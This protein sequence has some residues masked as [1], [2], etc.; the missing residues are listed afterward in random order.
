M[1]SNSRPPVTCA[2]CGGSTF[3]DPLSVR[4]GGWTTSGSTALSRNWTTIEIGRCDTCGHVQ[5]VTPLKPQEVAAM[6]SPQGW[7]SRALTL[8]NFIDRG[9]GFH[10][11]MFSFCQPEMFSEE[12][13]IADIGTGGGKPFQHCT[14]RT[15]SHWNDSSRLIFQTAPS[16]QS[17]DS[18][19]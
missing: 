15:V 13:S 7:D 2:V 18:S 10:D 4:C 9:K 6:Y 19:V 5:A 3:S 16:R 11:E 1:S 17:F 14:A 12:G 8:V